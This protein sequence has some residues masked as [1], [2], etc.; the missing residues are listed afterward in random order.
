MNLIKKAQQ[1]LDQAKQ[2]F[3]DYGRRYQVRIQYPSFDETNQPY[4]PKNGV[5]KTLSV[6][7]HELD[8]FR[9]QQKKGFLKILEEKPL[10][11][12]SRL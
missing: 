11:P 8:Q 4:F 3:M 12:R 5:T 7:V 1:A 6:S 9:E 2:Q 10:I